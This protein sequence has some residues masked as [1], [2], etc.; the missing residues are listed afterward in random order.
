MIYNLFVTGLVDTG[1][2]GALGTGCLASALPAVFETHCP[3]I[4]RTAGTGARAPGHSPPC[5]TAFRQDCR[6][7][8]WL[9]I[10]L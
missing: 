9:I 3:D 6:G 8:Y 4:L 1:L 2:S 10:N 5:C 7:K